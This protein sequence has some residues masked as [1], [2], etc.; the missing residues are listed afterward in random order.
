MKKNLWILAALL[1][2]ALALTGC[3][4]QAQPQRFDVATAPAQQTQNLL[5][6][7]ATAEPEAEEIDVDAI[8]FDSGDYDPASEE[9]LG[10]LE[11]TEET[12]NTDPEVTAVPTVNSVYAGATP[13][14]IDPSNKPTATPVPEI[15]FPY[16]TVDAAKA[17]VSFEAPADWVTDDSAESAVILTNPD[18]RMDYQAQ[19]TVTAVSVNSNYSGSEMKTEV[20]NQLKAIEGNS[21]Y[22][23]FETSNTDKRT[24]MDAAGYYANYTAVTPEGA[25]IAGRVHLT[26]I[27]RTL[28]IVHMSC[29]RAYRNAYMSASTG[30]YVH[31]RATMK[32]T[33]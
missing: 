16:A 19:I 7:A 28:Y 6:T 24:L 20:K 8:D 17:H 1:A 27:G 21:G 3:Q 31:L 9:G 18:T 5:G 26:C 23:H 22:T 30:P 13:V 4:Q 12:G 14:I 33:Q 32:I 15:T 29:P 11:D 2:L 10:D 25:E